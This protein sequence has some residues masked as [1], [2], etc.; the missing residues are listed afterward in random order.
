M[1]SYF[2]PCPYIKD[3]SVIKPNFACPPIMRDEI[4]TAIRKMKLGKVTGLGII[5]VELLEA[6]EDDGIDKNASSLNK[7]LDSVRFHETSPNLYL[8]HC[9]RNQGQQSANSIKQLV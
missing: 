3:Y 1:Q 7:I 2:V 6:L 9:Q 5:S 8:Q 4:G